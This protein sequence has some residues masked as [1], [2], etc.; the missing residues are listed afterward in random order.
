MALFGRKK[1]TLVKVKKK[2]IPAG[3]WGKCTD[4]NAVTYKKELEG[5]FN[6]CPKRLWYGYSQ[7]RANDQGREN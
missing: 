6:V 3:L 2:E 1:Y 4:C 7:I 5:N